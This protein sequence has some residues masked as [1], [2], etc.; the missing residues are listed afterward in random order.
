M[1]KRGKQVFNTIKR[2]EKRK[3]TCTITDIAKSEKI[4]QTSVNFHIKK[5]VQEGVIT[6]TPQ[7]LHARVSVV[8]K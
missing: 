8:D 1:T 6:Y 4:H 5:L 2:I 3:G 7:N